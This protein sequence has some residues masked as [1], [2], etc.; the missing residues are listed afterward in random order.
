MTANITCYAPIQGLA[1]SLDTLCAQAYGS[2]QKK[3]VGLQLQRM[4]YLI[5]LLLLPPIW[6]LWWHADV[7][8]AALLP[9]TEPQ[10]AQLAGQYLRVL[11]LGTPGYAAFET[12]KRF[13]MAQGLFHATTL[14]L[15]LGAPLN[16]V[17]NWFLV[18]RLDLGFLGAGLTIVCVQT[19]LPG[20]LL[21]YVVLVEGRECWGG[22]RTAHALRNW[23]P[24]LRLAL[25]GLVMLE[26]QFLA[27]EVL[28]LVSAQFGG[29]YLAA[30]SVIITITTTTFQLPFP[31]SIA[32]STRVANLVG[33]GLV[34]A[35]RL[36]AK[37]VSISDTIRLHSILPLFFLSFS[38]LHCLLIVQTK[39]RTL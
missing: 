8:L 6:L 39:E 4:T 22:L 11:I 16:L 24:M 21:G 26:A 13:V 30:Q 23:G 7:L 14:V 33:A 27:F 36:S 5:W 19:L 10:T 37:V 18:W 34:D 29:A 1:T 12:G 9:D 17:L 20:L 28:A 32:A 35:A 31:L 38:G 2:G 25:P 15:L 3:L